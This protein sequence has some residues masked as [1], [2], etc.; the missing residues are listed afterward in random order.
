MAG[1]RSRPA[2]SFSSAIRNRQ[3]TVFRGA[4]V[5]TYIA[6]KQVLATRDPGMILEITANFRSQAPILDFINSRFS[7]MLDGSQGQPE[8]TA[9]TPVRA[10]NTEP[11]VAAFEIALGDQQRNPRGDLVVDLVRHQEAETVAAILQR[12]IGAYPV[13][14]TDLRRFRPARA[15]DIALLAPTGTSLWIYERALEAREIPIA[16]QAGKGFFRRQEVQDLI[17]VARAIADRRDTFAL[18]ALLR[19]PLVG[20]TEEEIADE[21]ASLQNGAGTA[22]RLHLW[23]DPTRINNPV[24]KQTMLVL[25]NLAR[26]ARRTTPYQLLAEAVEQLQ[27]RPILSARHPRGAER[28]LA[29]VELVLEMAR[30][31]AARGIA[32]FARALWERWSDEDAQTEGRPDAEANAVSLLTIH[33]AKGLEWPI[34]IPINSTTSLWSDTHF[35]YRR[36]DDTVHFKVFDFP[37]LDYDTVAQA[38]KEAQRR[39]RVRLWYVAL[40]RARDLLLLPRQTERIPGDWLSLVTLDIDSLPLLDLTNF[41]GSL[42][43]SAESFNVQDLATWE[44]EAAIIAASERRIAWRQPSRHEGPENPAE[45]SEEIF[46]GPEAPLERLPRADDEIKAIQGGRVRGVILH[47]LLEEVL[48]RETDENVAALQARAA[49]LLAQLELMDTEDAAKGFSSSEMASTVHRAL[50]LPD[51]AALRPRLQ[52]EFRVYA[53]VQAGQKMSL[54]AGIA[55]AVASD[56]KGRIEAVIDWKSDVDPTSG[57]IE[58]YRAQVRDYLAATGAQLGLVV[59]LTSNRVERISI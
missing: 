50:Q 42:A 33:S 15:G 35:L 14:D 8:F 19:G 58:I 59:F 1:P 29:N 4:Y 20:L 45:I 6:A 16:T 2:P 26:K 9:L 57:Q 18:G 37:S 30:A 28:A 36:A 32:D 13:W 22:E 53:G 17:A 39:E 7:S 44:R 31:Y 10:R 40:T 55:D 51:V 24:L 46:V 25:Q 38:E 49:E 48:T 21:I 52:P 54:I 27:V 34:V 3:S 12:L 56:E 47:K 23:T 11:S 5:D 43:R 41:N